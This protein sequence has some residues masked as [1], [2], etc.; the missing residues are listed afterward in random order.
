MGGNLSLPASASFPSGGSTYVKIDNVDYIINSPTSDNDTILDEFTIIVCDR[1]HNPLKN[2]PVTF[3]VGHAGKY[4]LMPEKNKTQFTDH[5]GRIKMKPILRIIPNIT[6]Q[7]EVVQRLSLLFNVST[8]YQTHTGGI[9]VT[10]LPKLL[11]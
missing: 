10:I 9:T 6:I 2:V 8:K 3:T 7:E 11:D 1:S 4:L 5:K